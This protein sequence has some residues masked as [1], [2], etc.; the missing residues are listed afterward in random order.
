MILS[1]INTFADNQEFCISPKITY[2]QVQGN[3]DI[4]NNF[5]VN[6]FIVVYFINLPW[7]LG[8]YKYMFAILTIKT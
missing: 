3:K 7:L 8:S 5:L 6:R 4:S 1:Q 2:I